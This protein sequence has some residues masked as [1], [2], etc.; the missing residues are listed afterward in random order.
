[1]DT[2]KTLLYGLGMTAAALPVMGYALSTAFRIRHEMVFFNNLPSHLT[3]LRILH[4]TDLHCRYPDKMHSNIWPVL[5]TLDFD[6]VVLTGDVILNDI[7]QLKPHLEGLKALAEKAPVF[8]VD[9]NHERMC[10][11][12]VA[13][14]FESLGIKPLYN[15]RGDFE[16]GGTHRKQTQLLSVAGF[17]DYYYLKSKGFNELAPLLRDL[18]SNGDF[19]IILS[20]QPQIFDLLRKEN[21]AFSALVLA[22]HTHGGQLRLP[23][24]PTL[25][26]PGQGVLP[27]YGEGW[28]HSGNL[29]LYISRGVG[30]THFHIR[31]FNPPEVAVIELQKEG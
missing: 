25:Y 31:L 10:Y 26:A 29:K 7:T 1:M 24:L 21:L 5:L 27:H 8:F 6:M 17:R 12:E 4:I 14:L 18:S 22:G 20:H 2:K 16:V 15:Q 3:G 11:D 30:A 28:Y 19:H 9:G 23:F 13:K